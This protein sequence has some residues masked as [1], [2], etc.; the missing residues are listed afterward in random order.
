M[1]YVRFRDPA[2]S[3]RIGEWKDGDGDEDADGA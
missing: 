3:V 2:G 1:R